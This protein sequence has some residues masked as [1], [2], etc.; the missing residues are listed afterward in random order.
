MTPPEF[1]IIWSAQAKQMLAS[2]QDKRIQEKIFERVAKLAVEPEKQGKLLGAELADY[3]SLRAVGQ[4]YRVIYRVDED[5]VIVMVLAVGIRKEGDKKDVYGLVKKLV[6]L[7]L[8]EPIEQTETVPEQA[9][10][11]GSDQAQESAEQ[12]QA[13]DPSAADGPPLKTEDEQPWYKG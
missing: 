2:I 5:K 10:H 8:L 9:A 4:R 6:R 13:T 7:G 11:Q 1:T 3:R 12:S